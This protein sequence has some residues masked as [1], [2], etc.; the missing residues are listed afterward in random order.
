M[1]IECV[2]VLYCHKYPKNNFGQK[3]VDLG[4]KNNL[5]DREKKNDR[6][7][8]DIDPHVVEEEWSM[9]TYKVCICRALQC[10]LQSICKFLPNNNNNKKKYIN[11]SLTV[12]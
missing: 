5:P 3:S 8:Q 11:L 12:M 2:H 1:L 10:W 9:W 6:S 4:E 7:E